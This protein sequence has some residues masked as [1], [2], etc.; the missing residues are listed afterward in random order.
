MA[1]VRSKF[2][3]RISKRRPSSKVTKY[4]HVSVPL[5]S[6]CQ[7][8]WKNTSAKHAD[9]NNKFNKGPNEINKHNDLENVG[10][11]PR[12]HAS[13]EM[14]GHFSFGQHFREQVRQL[15]LSSV[16]AIWRWSIK[17]ILWPSE[18]NM[19]LATILE[20]VPRYC[21]NVGYWLND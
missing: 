11:T 17:F 9:P 19:C 8:H 7:I 18:V 3:H 20:Q 10:H 21:G 14:L 2:F 15:K 16:I 6:D 5:G 1:F 13:T 4:F 12:H